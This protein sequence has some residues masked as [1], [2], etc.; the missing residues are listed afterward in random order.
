MLQA[1]E[2][3]GLPLFL[4]SSSSTSFC[5]QQ[6]IGRLQGIIDEVDNELAEEVE[7]NNIKQKE[8]VWPIC[9]CCMILNCYTKLSGLVILVLLFAYAKPGTNVP[10][11]LMCFDSE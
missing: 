11:V 10:D 3:N 7:K 9:Y 2:D 6:E 4:F 1:K 5:Y 8:Q